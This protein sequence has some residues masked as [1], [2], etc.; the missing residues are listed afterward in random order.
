MKT[1]RERFIAA[2]ERRP[3]TGRVPHFELVFYLTME[4]FGRVHPL[5]RD[6]NQWLQMEEKERQLH[7]HDMADL[8]IATAEAYEHSAIFVH[9]NPGNFDECARLIE[10]IRQKTGDR[11]FLMK[12]GDATF[13][14]PDGNTMMEFS[15][16]MKDEPDKLKAEADQRVDEAL[17]KAERQKRLGGLDCFA[18]CTDYCFN[19]GPFLSPKKFSEFVAPYLTRLI[20]GYRELGFYTIKHTDG[21]IMPILDQLVAANPHALHSLDPQAGVDIA[22]VK[23]LYGDRVC[24]IGNVQCSSLDSGSEAE[25]R[26]SA[27]YALQQGMPGGGYIFA[28]SNCIYTGMPLANYEVMLDV[29]KEEGNYPD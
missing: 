9:P 22:E 1:H 26:G 7:R 4:A 25:I 28:T 21:N 2:L 24:L 13:G 8:Y 18:L 6:Y 19:T 12:H 5:H 14:I 15:F 23:R 29:W 27:R 17:Q 11:Y 10:I 16:R 3:L 20:R